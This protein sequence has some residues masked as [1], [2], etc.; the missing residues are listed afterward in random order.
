M[1]LW[2]GRTV[3]AVATSLAIACAPAPDEAVEEMAED[4][5]EDTREADLTTFDRMREREMVAFSEGDMATIREL[6][7]ADAVVL[8]PDEPAV[9]G[10]EAMAEWFAALH[11]AAEIDGSYQGAD[12]TLAGDV[13]YEVNRFTLTVTPEGGEAVTGMGKGVHIYRRQADGTWRIVLDIWNMDAP[14]GGS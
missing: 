8:P 11:E 4:T 9:E 1:S 5:V 3:M 12:V 10:I 2:T 14:A 6:F 7:A 13:A